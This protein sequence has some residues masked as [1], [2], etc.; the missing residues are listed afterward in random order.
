MF[1]YIQDPA[2]GE[3][4]DSKKKEWGKD[5]FP[6]SYAKFAARTIKRHNF[7]AIVV[8]EVNNYATGKVEYREVKDDIR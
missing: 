8:E 3:F 7:S 2:T 1:Y 5:G 6:Y 4:W